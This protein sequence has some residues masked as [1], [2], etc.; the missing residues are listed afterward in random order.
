MGL[1]VGLCSGIAG[2]VIAEK[3]IIYLVSS[4]HLYYNIEVSVVKHLIKALF[5]L[6][7]F[8]PVNQMSCR[9]RSLG[10]LSPL[11]G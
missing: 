11:S 4:F 1:S 10:R 7:F 5:M 3:L 6:K 2:F 9:A 8:G